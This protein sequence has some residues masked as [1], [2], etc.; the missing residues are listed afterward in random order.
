MTKVLVVMPMV[1]FS[2]PSSAGHDPLGPE[3]QSTLFSLSR[4]AGN[5]TVLEPAFLADQTVQEGAFHV[6]KPS[7]MA[8]MAAA[9]PR[10]TGNVA[11]L[12]L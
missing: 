12:T 6:A 7:S 2:V 9:E 11:A 1:A 5:V 3:S 8:A 10:L 4:E